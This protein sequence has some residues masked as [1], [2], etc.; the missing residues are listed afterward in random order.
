MKHYLLPKAEAGTILNDE[1]ARRYQEGYGPFG[2]AYVERRLFQMMPRLGHHNIGSSAMR[3]MRDDFLKQARQ[4]VANMMPKLPS[5]HSKF[6]HFWSEFI[7]GVDVRR[8]LFE[9]SL[10]QEDSVILEQELTHGGILICKMNNQDYR[11]TTRA[12]LVVYNALEN[13]FYDVSH[14]DFDAREIIELLL[15]SVPDH[16]KTASFEGVKSLLSESKIA[17]KF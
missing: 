12:E 6:P 8:W 15:K 1:V 9:V 10:A 5:W 3:Q 4:E 11:K 7:S 16:W 13:V 2:D 14:W 17:E